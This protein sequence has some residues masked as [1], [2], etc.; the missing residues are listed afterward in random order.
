MAMSQYTK[1]LLD[2][3]LKRELIP[4]VLTLKEHN[5]SLKNRMSEVNNEVAEERLN[6]CYCLVHLQKR[7]QTSIS[8]QEK[9]EGL[10]YR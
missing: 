1:E 3:L 9:T 2:K 8:S 7:L 10:N 6:Y 4:I 5:R